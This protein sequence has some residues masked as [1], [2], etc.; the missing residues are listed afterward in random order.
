VAT[1]RSKSGKFGL[2]SDMAKHAAEADR[3][4]KKMNEA[5]KSVVKDNYDAYYGSALAGAVERTKDALIIRL[6][7]G[8]Q[9]P[10]G[11]VLTWAYR[12][13]QGG[14]DDP[15]VPFTIQVRMD[16]DYVLGRTDAALGRLRNILNMLVHK[17]MV[18]D[19]IADHV[20][21]SLHK[22]MNHMAV[23]WQTNY[24]TTTHLKYQPWSSGGSIT[25]NGVYPDYPPA[26]P[27]PKT[28]VDWLR[29][30]VA[31]VTRVGKA[32]LAAA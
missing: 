8:D 31:E 11:E 9:P 12:T 17:G 5:L 1:R 7:E 16:R 21:R 28:N 24:S 4:F 3:A 10:R 32:E 26:P 19:H 22:E 25:T 20:L 30:Q 29:E 18:A 14:Y 2:G 6:Y 15:R 23:T 27:K 13:P